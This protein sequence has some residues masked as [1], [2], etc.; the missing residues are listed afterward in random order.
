MI[1]IQI[2]SRYEWDC[3]KRKLK[4]TDE[5]FY[6]YGEYFYFEINKKKCLFFRSGVRKTRA[7]GACQYIIC[8]YK[9]SSLYL[10]GSCGGVG[11]DV[12]I[13]D[14]VI[15]SKTVQYDC[16]PMN[17][18][19]IIHPTLI[20]DLDTEWAKCIR[21]SK[22][23]IIGTIGTADTPLYEIETVMKLRDDAIVCSDC[24]SA[25]VSII[26]K[27]NNINCRIIR[28]VTD[29]PYNTIDSMELQSEDCLNNTPI[30][31]DEILNIL[32]VIV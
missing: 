6:P 27:I 17:N 32:G 14:I 12:N 25:A 10:I 23:Y 5:L 2:C 19:N 9:I 26:C 29:L 30:I 22:P 31:F 4:I 3:I 13:L 18:K 8:N 11:T 7:S 16:L 21:T 28:G 15:A 24:E 1:G 20:T